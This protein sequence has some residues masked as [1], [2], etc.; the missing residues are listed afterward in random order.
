MNGNFGGDKAD[1]AGARAGTALDEIRKIKKSGLCE[2]CLKFWQGEKGLMMNPHPYLHC[3]H[4]SKPVGRPICICESG[5]SIHYVERKIGPEIEFMLS[6]F[7]PK[8]GRKL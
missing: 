6:K 2:E 1:Y 7:C 8:C 3:H 4:E 5:R